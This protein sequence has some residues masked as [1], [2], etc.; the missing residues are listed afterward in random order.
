[1]PNA[2]R[3]GRM[4]LLCGLWSLTPMLSASETALPE[5]AAAPAETDMRQRAEQCFD[6]ARAVLVGLES[7]ANGLKLQEFVDSGLTTEGSP[8]WEALE[9]GY[10]LDMPTDRKLKDYFIQ[11][12]DS[13]D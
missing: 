10:R 4:L 2:S 11:C 5:A 1:M 3:L 6:R 9:L 8:E 13:A 7:R 12:L